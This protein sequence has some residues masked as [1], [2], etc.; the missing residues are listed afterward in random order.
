MQ[1]V[2]TEDQLDPITSRILPNLTE[3]PVLPLFAQV[4]VRW[5]KM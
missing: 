5:Q 2:R 1:R 3:P 4:F